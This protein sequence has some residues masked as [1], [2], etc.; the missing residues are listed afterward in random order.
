M[1]TGLGPTLEFYA[2][3]SAEIQRCDLGLWNESD[4]YRAPSSSIVDCV[5]SGI[6]DMDDEQQMSDDHGNYSISS[7]Y[8]FITIRKSTQ[9]N[10]ISPIFL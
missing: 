8:L 1:G 7:S 10:Q 2:L 4:T 9:I 6:N 3:V 5:K